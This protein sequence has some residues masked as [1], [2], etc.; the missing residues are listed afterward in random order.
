M[1]TC[2]FP[3]LFPTSTNPHVKLDEKAIKWIIREKEKGTPTKEIAEI[4]NITPR[5]VNQIYK[6]YKDT[7]E[8][9]KPKKPGRPKKELSEEEIEAIKEAYEEYRCNA[10]VLQ[11]ILKERGYRISKNKIHE[12]LRMNGYAKEEKN[13]KKRKKWIRY[14]RKHSM[15][16]WHADWFF[17]NGKWI[18]AYLD[19]ASRLITGYGVFDKATS[20]NAIKVLKEAMDDYGRPESI[21]TD[22]GT[23]F[24]A[25][26]GEKKAKGVSKFE[27][28]L[29]ENEIKHI[30]GRVNHPQTNGKIERFY[31]TLEAKIKYFDTVDEFMEWYNHKRPHMSL[32]L[33]E[34]ETPY[35]AFLRKLTP[36]RILSYSWRWFDGGK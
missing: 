12:V 18:I 19:D 23:Q 31:G 25:S 10:V 29:A 26:A 11:T 2:L 35:K 1:L 20:E 33:D 24:Y 16:L 36:E 17:Y 15:E 22:R 6:Q 4:E 34:L 28:F 32:N 13:K 14:E 9:P 5:R 21:L 8:I 3:K 27:K 7:G 30:V